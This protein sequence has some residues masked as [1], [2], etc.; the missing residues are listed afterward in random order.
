MPTESFTIGMVSRKSGM[1]NSEGRVSRL[2][3]SRRGGASVDVFVARRKARGIP[4]GRRRSREGIAKMRIP[5][6]RWWEEPRHFLSAFGRKPIC[7]L[8][9]SGCVGGDVK[10]FRICE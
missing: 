4:Q 9:C 1:V 5:E 7:F 6:L 2:F 8:F 10:S 3:T